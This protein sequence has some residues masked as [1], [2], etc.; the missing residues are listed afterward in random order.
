V[1]KSKSFVFNFYGFCLSG[2]T[3]KTCDFAV[4]DKDPDLWT[5]KAHFFRGHPMMEE[6]NEIDEE[7]E[8]EEEEEEDSLE[9]YL[10][11]DLLDEA[12]PWMPQYEIQAKVDSQNFDGSN[13]YDD[14]QHDDET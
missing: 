10:T 5:R 13:F 3:R 8:E 4:R 14:C 12:I 6:E 2:H 1:S 11:D 7:E 9:D